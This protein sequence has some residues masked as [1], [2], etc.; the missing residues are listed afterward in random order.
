MV[1]QVPALTVSWKPGEPERIT[2]DNRTFL[3]GLDEMYREAMGRVESTELLACAQQIAGKLRISPAKVP[4]EGYY[5]ESERLT[6]YFQLMRA[7]QKVPEERT[8]E[9]KSLPEF[10]RLDEVTSSALYGRPERRGMLFAQGTD[11][12]TI[13]LDRTRPDWS[14]E[15][16]TE[17]AEAEA[18]ARDDYSLVGLAALAR[19]PV[20]LTALRESVVLYEHVAVFSKEV[21]TVYVWAV[22]DN[23]TRQAVRFVHTFN[24][25]FR[26]KLPE[27]GPGSAEAYY[28]AS[29]D[30]DIDGRCV[31][32][33]HDLKG[34]NYHWAIRWLGS[35]G[36]DMHEFW[37][38]STWTTERYR[39]TPRALRPA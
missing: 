29:E 21:P 17:V 27:P 5:V 35:N 12:V 39:N 14:V 9:V 7:L 30:A 33:G 24:S 28:K 38:A 13:A 1:Q 36:L 32:M 15:K 37:D 6:E 11:P 23:L 25:L 34:N 3:L 26:G 19:D 18:R 31:R 2:V 16:V 4:V 22:D 8:S 20:I 10:K